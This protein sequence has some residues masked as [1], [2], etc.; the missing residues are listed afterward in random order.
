MINNNKLNA[1][2]NKNP[3]I[4]PYFYE[5]QILPYIKGKRYFKIN[6]T[7]TMV[8]N[9]AKKLNISESTIMTILEYEYE[10]ISKTI[11]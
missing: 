2:I 6:S 9:V 3:F 4:G 5:D 7:E 11:N 1:R 10:K 8:R